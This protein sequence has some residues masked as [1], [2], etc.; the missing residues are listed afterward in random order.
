M[1]RTDVPPDQVLF[2]LADSSIQWE[3]VNDSGALVDMF[4]EYAITRKSLISSEQPIREQ[5]GREDLVESVES[6]WSSRF[7]SN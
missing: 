2:R 1:M 7:S 3:W 6:M 4:S 5:I